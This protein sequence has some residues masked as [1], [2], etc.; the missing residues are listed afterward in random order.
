MLLE[1]VARTEPKYVVEA[2][3]LFRRSGRLERALFLNKR[4]A[5]QKAKI[6]Q[7]LQI[8]L[9]LERFEMIVAM[10]ARHSGR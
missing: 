4:I 6:K 10:E 8:L 1:R 7:R 9:E 5:D 2:A 3:E